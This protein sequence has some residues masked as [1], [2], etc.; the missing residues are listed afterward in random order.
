MLKLRALGVR[1]LSLALGCFLLISAIVFRGGLLA[2]MP[3]VWA[4]SLDVSAQVEATLPNVV[5]DI[6]T[7]GDNSVQVSDAVVISGT[8]PVVVPSLVV[9]LVRDNQTI[10]TGVCE[11]TGTFRIL[12]GLVL[13]ENVIYPRFMTVTGQISGY[14][15]PIHL[16]YRP[17]QVLT[18]ADTTSNATQVPGASKNGL[19]IDFSYDFVQAISHTKTNL[20]VN[21]RG[22]KPPYRL[23]VQ[24]GDGFT[25]EY[26]FNEPGL[27]TI[28]HI[29]A[30]LAEGQ[31]K[32]LLTLIDA[33]GFSIKS[34]R[35]LLTSEKLPPQQLTAESS[36]RW[37]SVILAVALGAG[38]LVVPALVHSRYRAVHSPESLVYTAKKRRKSGNGS[39]R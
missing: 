29:Y 3:T 22:G 4:D 37:L 18:P 10:G 7:P 28:T 1:R 6:T 11:S 21:I 35:A 5:P 31:S 12:V 2:G 30:A 26:T 38:A 14:G 33:N 32:I 36:G 13:G 34:E 16:T 19:A 25:K 39:V 23:I 24:W 9:V 20:Q 27:Q 15:D 8:C 17:K